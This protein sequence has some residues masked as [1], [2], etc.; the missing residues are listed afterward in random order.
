[1]SPRMMTKLSKSYLARYLAGE[2]EAVWRELVALR[3]DVS[4]PSVHD[5]ALNVARETMRRVLA[6]TNQLVLRL[7]EEG[8]RFQ[9]PDEILVPP[10]P[11]TD[12]K[13]ARIEREAG[14]LPLSLRAAFEVVGTINLIGW[15]DD[16]SPEIGEFYPDPLEVTAIDYAIAELEDWHAERA[17]DEDTAGPFGV[18]ISADPYHKAGVSGGPQYRIFVGAPCAD[19]QLVNEQ[20]G[21]LFVEYL[22]LCFGYGGF[23]GWDRDKKPPTAI[24]DRLRSDLLEI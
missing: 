8:Y 3:E 9:Y 15:H 11:D 13:I 24:L 4:H 21:I 5:D 20:H 19:G 22:R 16:L 1:M 12:A 10:P 6:N 17:D 7:T 18:P 2:R 23:P 14:V